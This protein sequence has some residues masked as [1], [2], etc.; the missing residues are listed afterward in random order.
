MSVTTQDFIVNRSDLVQTRWVSG[1]APAEVSL[2]RGQ[3]LAEVEKFAFT[4]NNTTYAVAGD[5]LNYWFFSLP[6]PAGD[7]FRSE[8]MRLGC[9]RTRKRLPP[10][11]DSAAI[12]RCHRT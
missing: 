1:L 4:A 3:I 6:K 11:R 10:A 2:E 12:S 8:A 9:D 5:L 7:E